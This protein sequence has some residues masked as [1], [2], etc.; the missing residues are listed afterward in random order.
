[1]PGSTPV[2]AFGDFLTA[3]VATLGINPSRQE[4]TTAAGQLLT[5]DQRRLASLES[6]GVDVLDNAPTRVV[7]QVI[8][9][10]INYFHVKPYRR[11]FDQLDRLLQTASSTSYYNGS[12]CHLDLVQWATDP[13][14]G[15]ITNPSTRQ[16][17]LDADRQF[18]RQQLESEHIEV[19]LINGAGVMA[20]VEAAYGGRFTQ[21]AT[22]AAGDQ[23]SAIYEA[24]LFGKRF[25]AWR[26][27]FQA[28][29][30]MTRGLKDEIA[31]RVGALLHG[32]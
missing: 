12:A 21:V 19:V 18:L 31:V 30:G 22:A 4:F 7:E 10:C 20:V 28:Q 1:M 32:G 5:G 9:E 25:V 23:S 15:G 6:L 11:W 17:L 14:W 8:A 3:T 13:V 2:V 24:D 27:N 29:R 16:R 26:A